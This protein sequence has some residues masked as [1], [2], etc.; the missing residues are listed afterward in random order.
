MNKRKKV[1]MRKHRMKR[2]KA[3]EKRKLGQL[4]RGGSTARR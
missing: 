3:E 1:A 4:A 2:K